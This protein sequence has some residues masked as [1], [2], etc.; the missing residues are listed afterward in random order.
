MANNID[1]FLDNGESPEQEYWEQATT[2]EE[3]L[4]VLSDAKDKGIELVFIKEAE[5]SFIALVPKRVA[6]FLA[7]YLCKQH[8]DILEGLGYI[9]DKVPQEVIDIRNGTWEEVD[10]SSVVENSGETVGDIVFPEK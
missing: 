3:I 9:G 7:P 6:K 10:K 1:G 2:H 4:R 8:P 5:C